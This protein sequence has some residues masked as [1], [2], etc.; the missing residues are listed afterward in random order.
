MART[1]S[2]VAGDVGAIASAIE[3][4]AGDDELAPARGAGGTVGRGAVRAAYPQR[5]VEAVE[6]AG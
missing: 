4:A 6:D 1:G 5:I 3:R 2:S